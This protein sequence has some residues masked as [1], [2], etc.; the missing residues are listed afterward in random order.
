LTLSFQANAQVGGLSIFPLT[1]ELT[2][3]PGD[4]LVEKI[5]VY[6]SGNTIL[7]IKMEVEDFKATEKGQVII[8]AEEKTTYSLKNWVKIDPIEFTLTPKE[9]KFVNVVIDIPKNAEPGGKYGSILATATEKEVT[10]KVGSLILL[11]VSGKVIENLTVK[12]FSAPEF[13][14]SEPIPFTVRFENKGT[15]QAKPLGSIIIT[16]CQNKEI[17]R[18]ALPQKIVLPGAVRE[19]E[20]SWD[21]KQLNGCYTAILVGTYGTVNTPF[22]SEKIT[23]WVSTPKTKITSERFFILQ[24]LIFLLRAVN[25]WPF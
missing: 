2:A 8:G 13:S 5:K 19:I 23:F 12:E 1:L 4:T 20:V 22:T 3:N 11:T 16:D 25:L 7:S 17:D 14:E 15:V 21:K 24:F 6:N 18:I 9:E 10:Q